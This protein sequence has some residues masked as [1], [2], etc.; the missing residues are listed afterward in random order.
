MEALSANHR[1]ARAFALVATSVVLA[2]GDEGTARDV[3]PKDHGERPMVVYN[4]AAIARPMRAVLDS[5]RVETGIPYEQETSASL[6]LARKVAELGGE[7]DVIAL[8]DPEIFPKLLEPRFTTWHALFGRNRIVLAY[9]P[10]SRGAAE[11][12]PDNWFRVLGRS[13]VE[14]GRADPNTDPSG[15]RT[16]LVWQLAERHYKEPGLYAR[17]LRAAPAKNVRPREADQVALLEVG[18][19]DYIWTYQNLAENAGLRY[20]KL[21]DAIDLGE[22]AD[23]ATYALASVRVAGRSLGDSLTLTG[24]PILFAVTVPRGARHRDAAEQF[25]GFLLSPTGRRILRSAHFDAIET[26][27]VVGS[28]APASLQP[29]PRR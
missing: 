24:R 29:A 16:L 1:I 20:V 26:P 4:A 10:R 12:T 19:Y 9:T 15:Y 8:A 21:P 23:S 7:P 11:I 14:V 2:C 13:G 22:P 6:E 3:S 27:A 28:G 18:E 25:V 5:F 17:M